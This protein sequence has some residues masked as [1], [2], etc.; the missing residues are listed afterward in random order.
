MIVTVKGYLTIRT[1]MGDRHL[2]EIEV[3]SITIHKLLSRLV[4]EFGGDF[5]H[6]IFAPES[7]D[8]SPHIIVLVNGR[9][10]SHLPDGLS[11]ELNDGDEV[12]LFPP[13]A[14]G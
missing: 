1:V 8:L 13:I 14:G 5:E 9:H 7:Q 10:V 3:E 6:M 12:A 2:Q 4:R 11:T